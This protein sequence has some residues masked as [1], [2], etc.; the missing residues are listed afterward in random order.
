MH[1]FVCRTISNT[2]YTTSPCLSDLQRAGAILKSIVA[3]LETPQELSEVLTEEEREGLGD[4]QD[5]LDIVQSPLFAAVVD[6]T[7]KCKK[8]GR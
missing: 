7:D 5:M 1:T 8:V 2:V 3:D 4:L 6:I